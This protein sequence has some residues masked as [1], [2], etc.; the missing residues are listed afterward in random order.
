MVAA[1]IA[2]TAASSHSR[3][4]D[5]FTLGFEGSSAFLL[6]KG[7]CMQIILSGKSTKPSDNL[8]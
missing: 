1:T 4:N 6:I 3:K 2:K 7:I 8:L 5:F